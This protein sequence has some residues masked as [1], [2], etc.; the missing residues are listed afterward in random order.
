MSVVAGHHRKIGAFFF[1]ILVIVF[2]AILFI[3]FFES[4][5]AQIGWPIDWPAFWSAMQ[6]GDLRYVGVDGLRPPPWSMLPLLPLGYV[7]MRTGWALLSLISLISLILSV[8]RH[9]YQWQATVLLVLSFPM[10]RV[11]VDGNFEALIVGGVALSVYAVRRH[12]PLML[13]VGVVLATYKPQAVFLLLLVLA[14][15]LLYEWS[16][17]E[18][19][20]FAAATALIVGFAML[21]R[22]QEWLI[23]VFGQNFDRY[24]GTLIDVTLMAALRRLGVESPV[25][26]LL[27]W[28]LFSGLTLYAVFGRGRSPLNRYTAGFLSAA[29]L[30]AAP[31][32][33]GNSLLVPY[34]I[35]IIPLLYIRT[36]WA[37]VLVVCV[38][39]SYL[40]N[41][42]SNIGWIAY[43]NT[44]LLLVFW[45]T[46][47]WHIWSEK[48]AAQSVSVALPSA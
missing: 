9:R 34:A 38:N 35:G 40:T 1:V 14:V 4:V 16:R 17:S 15:T 32:A 48:K 26:P 8:P 27:V 22:G 31:Y 6:H 30:L 41:D 13:A 5:P 29:S 39:L 44:L 24:T 20:K 12:Q 42:V 18:Q 23:A 3:N 47:F 33:A 46:L 25:I 37:I 36:R 43:Y 11:I 10:L 28:A 21:W 45:A 7:S 19:L 2:I